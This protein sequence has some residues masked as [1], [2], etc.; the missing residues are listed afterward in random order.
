MFFS[1]YFLHMC[2]SQGIQGTPETC[3]ILTT[4]TSNQG[5]LNLGCVV[6]A[7][8][9]L[10]HHGY[11]IPPLITKAQWAAWFAADVKESQCPCP[12]GTG[13]ASLALCTV[14]TVVDSRSPCMGS[15][16]FAI[17]PC[18]C[19][20]LPIYS[21]K[22]LWDFFHALLCVFVYKQHGWTGFLAFVA[23]LP[24]WRK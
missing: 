9:S 16:S 24:H 20:V 14:A 6:F 19:A 10:D 17:S 4:V 22:S 23:H 18:S 2:L 8:S 13:V 1:C 21:S 7:C 15:G 5:P 12:C 11:D 3:L